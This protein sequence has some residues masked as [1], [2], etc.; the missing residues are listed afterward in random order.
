MKI[1]VINFLRLGDILMTSPIMNGLRTKYPEAQIHH[2]GFKE[3]SVARDVMAQI[4]HWHFISR[5]ELIYSC[6][7]ALDSLLA[8]A[9]L[10]DAKCRELENLNF[11]LVVNLS[12]TTFS[13]ICA[14]LI[15]GRRTMGVHMDGERLKFSSPAFEQ[16]NNQENLE[17]RHYLDWFRIGL[18]M[19]DETPDWSFARS[20][21][22][23]SSKS[24]IKEGRK[25]YLFQT[26][27]SDEKK[28]WS[29]ERWLELFSLIR[30]KDPFA[31]LK[32]LCAPFEKQILSPL[33][34][35]GEVEL[36]G[37]GLKEAHTQIQKADVFITLDTS[38][39]HLANDS[40][41]KV[42]ELCFGSSD[43]R[44]Q[45][46]YRQ[47]AVILTPRDECYPCAPRGSCPK[48]QRSC[49]KGVPPSDVMNAIG[50]L[51]GEEARFS[52]QAF[53]T[54]SHSLWSCEAIDSE[55]GEKI[56]KLKSGKK[57][58]ESHSEA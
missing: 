35:K 11:D 38:T 7:D 58:V 24:S 10:I 2:L 9:D 54:T 34:E 39:K 27:S 15:K 26:L 12:H 40:N 51:E 20:T 31:E 43:H 25:V 1:L 45:S 23:P 52:S 41:C 49:L 37:V 3:F 8:P 47:G 29:M 13:A 56:E 4:D 44:K 36:L 6:R 5:S 18:G 22:R 21:K 50:F 55:K 57:T 30:R 17:S 48:A 28:A 19:E 53:V 16:L 32:L 33:A 46:I 42:I 14:G